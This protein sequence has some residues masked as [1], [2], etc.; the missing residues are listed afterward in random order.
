MPP[1]NVNFNAFDS[2]FK[3]IFAHRSRSTYTSSGSSAQSTVIVR[4]EPL[5]RGVEHGGQLPGVGRQVQGLEV[6]LEPA[7]LQP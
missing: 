5:G 1:L 6:R 4:A 2:R 3:T 7:G